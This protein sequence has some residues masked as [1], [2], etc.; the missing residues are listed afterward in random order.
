MKA[1]PI[2]FSAPMV[3]A[4]LAGTKTQT[5][6]VVNVPG[7]DPSANKPGVHAPIEPYHHAPSGNWN[8]VLSATGHGLGDPFRCPYGVPG[9]RLW[10]R[11]TW[12]APS[13][14]DH[15]SPRSIADSEGVRF[16]ADET[17]GAGPGYGKKRPGM[18]MPRWASRLTLEITEVRVERL[19]D[20]SL[21]DVR[22]EGCEVRAFWLFGAEAAERQRIGANVYRQLWEQINGAGSWDA[23][24]WVWALTFKSVSDEAPS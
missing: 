4:L 22:A 5:R 21:N 17:V 12:R 14:C 13:S 1:R 16:V 15:L 18:F 19:Q 20:I 2:L 3:R 8:F 7:R 6:R 11:E 23:N 24:P 10:C 9:D